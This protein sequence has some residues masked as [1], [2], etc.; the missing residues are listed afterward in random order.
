M[1]IQKIIWNMIKLSFTGFL[2]GKT[3]ADRYAS[4]LNVRGM[5]MSPTFNPKDYSFMGCSIDDLV[6]VEKF[7]LQKYKFSHG[8]VVLFRSPTNFKEKHIKRIVALPGEWIQ[9]PNSYGDV[10]KIPAGYCWVEGD[11]LTSSLDSRSFGPI[12]LGLICG[13]VTHILWPPGRVGAVDTSFSTDRH[14]RY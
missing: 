10:V 9:T 7:C 2:V 13:R 8:D 5:S 6:L 14:T 11:N 12:P 3:V 1:G 4:V